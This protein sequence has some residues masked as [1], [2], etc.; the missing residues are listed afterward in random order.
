MFQ[1]SLPRDYDLKVYVTTGDAKDMGIEEVPAYTGTEPTPLVPVHRREGLGGG[2][3]TVHPLPPLLLSPPSPS[4]FTKTNLEKY[5][6][7]LRTV[8]TPTPLN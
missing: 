6:P 3:G 1:T 4:G 7:R 8:H 2:V 5:T